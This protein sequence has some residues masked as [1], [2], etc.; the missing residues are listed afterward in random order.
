[1]ELNIN[2]NVYAPMILVNH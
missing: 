2:H 1:M